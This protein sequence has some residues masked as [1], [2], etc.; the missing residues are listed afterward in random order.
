MIFMNTY[1]YIYIYFKRKNINS[2]SFEETQIFKSKSTEV[3]DIHELILGNNDN[4]KNKDNNDN[5]SNKEIIKAMIW[6]FGGQNMYNIS[7]PF[8]LSSSSLYLF[9]A[10]GRT[11]TPDSLS[12][13]LD[14]LLWFSIKQLHQLQ[15]K[16]EK[17]NIIL[18]VTHMDELTHLQFSERNDEFIYFTTHKYILSTCILCKWIYRRRCESIERKNK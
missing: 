13:W 2:L 5:N 14:L 10:N 6:D 4:N 9:V 16:K 11:D 15:H 1:T 17:N 3:I 12:H 7:H 18:V 8:F